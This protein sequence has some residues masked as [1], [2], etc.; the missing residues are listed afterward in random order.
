MGEEEDIPLPDGFLEK[1]IPLPSQEEEDIPIPAGMVGVQELGPLSEEESIPIPKDFSSGSSIPLPPGYVPP[2]PVT[3]A[4]ETKRSRA[5]IWLS[6][7][8]SNTQAQNTFLN[9]GRTSLRVIKSEP[10]SA[11]A[12]AFLRAINSNT[13]LLDDVGSIKFV[14]GSTTR[15]YQSAAKSVQALRF[16]LEDKSLPEDTRVEARAVHDGLI[17]QMKLKSAEWESILSRDRDGAD[18]LSTSTGGTTRALQPGERRDAG[19]T[20]I[21]LTTQA[22]GKTIASVFDVIDVPAKM[23]GATYM[24]VDTPLTWDALTAADSSY[25]PHNRYERIKS[26]AKEGNPVAGA[27]MGFAGV[28][29]TFAGTSFSGYEMAANV[30]FNAIDDRGY[31]YAEAITQW[32]HNVEGAT[33]MVVSITTDPLI[34]ASVGRSGAKQVINAVDDIMRRGGFP[35]VDDLGRVIGK[36]EYTKAARDRVKVKVEQAIIDGNDPAISAFDKGLRPSGLS[37]SDEYMHGEILKKTGRSM[38]EL[39]KAKIHQERMVLESMTKP[40]RMERLAR[41]DAEVARLERPIKL[42]EGGAEA[43]KARA[44]SYKEWVRRAD[45]LSPDWKPPKDEVGH[46]LLEGLPTAQMRGFD[47]AEMHELWPAMVRI[48]REHGI[49]IQELRATFGKGGAFVGA[50]EASYFG[51]AIRVPGANRYAVRRFFQRNAPSFRGV[52]VVGRPLAAVAE[53]IS[54]SSQNLGPKGSLFTYEGG[55][56]G[57][58]GRALGRNLQVRFENRLKESFDNVPSDLILD[59]DYMEYVVRAAIDPD[60]QLVSADGLILSGR[61]LNIHDETLKL[62]TLERE[63]A[64]AL[65][66]IDNIDDVP[67]EIWN[68][69]E[70]AKIREAMAVQQRRV[71]EASKDS[72]YGDQGEIFGAPR[73]AQTPEGADVIQEGIPVQSGVITYKDGEAALGREAYQQQSNLVELKTFEETL[74]NELDPRT[75]TRVTLD[76][77]ALTGDAN[78]FVIDLTRGTDIDAAVGGLKKSWKGEVG[79]DPLIH[80]EHRSR[81]HSPGAAQEMT[82]SVRESELK[83]M[84]FRSPDEVD[85]GLAAGRTEEGFLVHNDAFTP[86][87]KQDVDGNWFGIKH[88]PTFDEGAYPITVEIKKWVDDL[89]VAMDEIREDLVHYGALTRDQVGHNPLTDGYFPRN[90]KEARALYQETLIPDNIYSASKKASPQKGRGE[91]FGTPL[92]RS[93]EKL[94]GVVPEKMRE[95]VLKAQDVLSEYTGVMSRL[96]AGHQ[97]NLAYLDQFGIPKSKFMELVKVQSRG[98]GIKEII[99]DPKAGTHIRY[100]KPP[101]GRD[102][103]DYQVSHELDYLQAKA[104]GELKEVLTE[105][106]ANAEWEKLRKQARDRNG[107]EI[108]GGR[109]KIA[110]NAAGEEV[111]IPAKVANWAKA[112]SQGEDVWDTPYFKRLAKEPGLLGGALRAGASLERSIKRNFARLLLLPVPGYHMVNGPT[113][114]AQLYAKLGIHDMDKK[115]SLA[116]KILESPKSAT[117]T[118]RVGSISKTYSGVDIL[119]AAREHEIGLGSLARLDLVAHDM[120]LRKQLELVA[121]RSNGK[122]LKLSDWREF[123]KNPI[124]LTRSARGK[125]AKASPISIGENV[126][127]WWSDTVQMTGFIHQVS[128]GDSFAVAA[129]KSLKALIPYTEQ[130]TALKIM[131]G[132]F[133]IITWAVKAP[134]ATGAAFLA[135]PVP[136]IVSMRFSEF[137][138]EKARKESGEA[139]QLPVW[140]Q[141]QANYRRVPNTFKRLYSIGR[142]MLGGTEISEDEQ[143]YVKQRAIP[144]FE[145]WQMWL[146]MGQNVFST[147]DNPIDPLLFQLGPTWRAIYEWGSDR[148]LFTKKSYEDIYEFS[149]PFSEGT[150]FPRRFGLLGGDLPTYAED[151]LSFFGKTASPSQQGWLG[152]NV[153]LLG[154]LPGLKLPFSRPGIAGMNLLNYHLQGGN[155]DPIVFGG[156]R[157]RT[158][159][160]KGANMLAQQ[161]LG[162][163]TGWGSLVQ[164]PGKGLSAIEMSLDRSK[165]IRDQRDARKAFEE[166][167]KLIEQRALREASKK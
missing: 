78:E 112:F 24:G 150:G 44:G 15:A 149:R 32:T 131:K 38:D 76:K 162:M 75:L 57:R 30:L 135:N 84:T 134:K 136:A 161:M 70:L 129:E 58:K 121:M 119:K 14:A 120:P 71:R 63:Y 159:D 56:I 155:V 64:E 93:E 160:D 153:G 126:A 138:E 127:A 55:H 61:R 137:L 7:Q 96:A 28:I 91:Q 89:K 79:A 95:P 104:S 106:R 46:S 100:G 146:S 80:F 163:F 94:R 27:F 42:L 139:H 87:I 34:G 33:E 50:G 140:A 109:Y 98:R 122:P 157:D 154:S 53:K 47:K 45:E 142:K 77:R 13:E 6:K 102:A 82:T 130:D 167:M 83:R 118:A 43:I 99:S 59:D 111:I 147:R 145:A 60:F 49:P 17:E 48:G 151:Q 1:D 124:L 67:D 68:Q 132:G 39:V 10:A 123:L 12:S 148:D 144:L 18:P 52:P 73:A 86:T 125:A 29:G 156:A 152:K 65:G 40:G 114:V 8:I 165:L 141:E 22:V 41:A 92:G 35:I 158:S 4:P 23:L 16:M 117:V 20:A 81:N 2:P 164:T 11:K 31:S 110:E 166:Y 113:D 51:K 66:P 101:S 62:K 128:K 21:E 108:S 115:M 3:K 5:K 143:L 133:P 105:R 36:S 9:L 25:S 19:L 90:Y 72:R 88:K 69:P 85:L 74:N 116:R 97:V 26:L 37:L 103:L 107:Q 54:S